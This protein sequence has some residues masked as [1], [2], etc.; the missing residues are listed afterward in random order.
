[1]LEDLLAFTRAVVP[2]VICCELP[3]PEIAQGVSSDDVGDD[4]EVQLSMAPAVGG[5]LLCVDG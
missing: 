3:M 4:E 1:M 5:R 2:A